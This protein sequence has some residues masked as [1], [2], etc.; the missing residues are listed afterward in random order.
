MVY[1]EFFFRATG[2]YRPFPYQLRF[3]ECEAGLRVLEV[4]TGLGKT[5]A[6]LVDWLERRS[7]TRLVYCLPGRTLTRQIADI[8]RRRVAAAGLEKQVKVLELMGGSEDLD[9]TLGPEQRA[10]LV[11][12]QDILVSRALN[13][14][15]ARSPF[16]WPIDFALLN[17]DAMWVFDEVQLLGEAVAT[18][19]QMAAFRTQ[20]ETFGRVPCVWMSATFER[21]WLDTVDFHEEPVHIGLTE[22]DERDETVRK[23]LH[24]AKSI[25]ETTECSTP[26]DCARF[27]L[28]RHREDK[29]TVMIANT[30]ARAQEIWDELRKLGRKDAHLLHSRFRPCDREEITKQALEAQAGVIVSTQVIEAGVDLDAHLMVT[31][32]AP[33]A[34]LVQRFG[35]VN[36]RGSDSGEIFWVR[37]P[38]RA[39]SKTKTD[40][41]EFAP[42]EAS[43]VREAIGVL[44]TLQS[45][46]PLALKGK[47]KQPAPYKNVLRGR[48]LLD[49]FDTTPDLAGNHI[50]IS[51]FVRSGEETSVYI[52]WREWPEKEAPVNERV[53]QDELCPVPFFPGGSTDLKALLKKSS[54]WVWN[55]ADGKWER[56]DENSRLYAGMQILLR[57][58]AGGYDLKRGWAP[59]SKANVP[60]RKRPRDIPK[61]PNEEMNTDPW[62]ETVTQTLDGHTDEVVAELERI[63][64][65][66]SVELNGVGPSLVTAARYHDWGKAHPV[67]QQTLHK[68]MEVPPETAPI[69]LLAKQQRSLSRGKH[70]RKGFRHELASALALLEREEWLAAYIVMAHHGKVRMNIRSLP[71]EVD[72]KRQ[73]DR[74]ARGIEEGDRLFAA[75]LGGGVCVSEAV[76]HLQATKLGEVDGVSGWADR[77]SELLEKHGPFRLAYLEM[78]LRA[79][80]ESASAKAE[81]QGQ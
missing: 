4:P 48:D 46:A 40:G 56:I 50:D 57:S 30:V 7:T 53:W 76:L 26:Q 42:Y 77:V 41:S 32:V 34:S 38:Q 18:S 81:R 78:L 45:G 74:V 14:G 47:V 69:P 54:G 43:E 60:E 12:T 64:G 15:Y 27:L 28:D 62:S 2:G 39:K 13:R 80:D 49:L 61:I 71:G 70:S 5:D 16:R 33:W 37:S 17:N 44:E 25:Q 67:F 9:L 24:A 51:R 21:S 55:Y 52:A 19:A 59:E 65:E 23:R 10:I 29:L 75:E 3:H 31:D 20:F 36:R 68:G 58:A 6:V 11:G 79:A 73:T 8:A 35:R 1:E 22:E 63:T 66:L 72:W